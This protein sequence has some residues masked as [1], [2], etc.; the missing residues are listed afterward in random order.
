M[1]CFICGGSG[2]RGAD[3]CRPCKQTGWIE[4][5]GCGMVDPNVFEFV[6]NN[7]YDPKKVSGIRVWH[8]RGPVGV[9]EIWS[10]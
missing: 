3:P 1:T 7:G 4:V 10:R 8:G 9:V 5:L 6:K 2:K